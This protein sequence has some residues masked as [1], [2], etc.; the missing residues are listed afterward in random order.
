VF[1]SLSTLQSSGTPPPAFVAPGIDPGGQLPS[2]FLGTESPGFVGGVNPVGNGVFG[3]LSTRQ[4]WAFPVPLSIDPGGH[5]PSGPGPTTSPGFTTTGVGAG[6]GGACVV[7]LHAGEVGAFIQ[8]GASGGRSPLQPGKSFRTQ[9]PVPGI[10]TT[11]PCLHP[12]MF[13]LSL[14]VA[15]PVPAG[16]DA[17]VPAFGSGHVIPLIGV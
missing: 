10:P 16:A 8:N 14:H 3:S 1:G 9:N 2:G 15:G 13:G 17:G 11:S 6:P 12:G 7:C 4:F 5:F